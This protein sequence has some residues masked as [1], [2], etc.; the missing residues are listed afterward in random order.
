MLLMLGLTTVDTAVG[1]TQ[2]LL[3]LLYLTA[4]VIILI[5]G[6]VILL[7]F[8]LHSFSISVFHFVKDGRWKV[9]GAMI[10][11]FLVVGESEEGTLSPLVFAGR[12]L[13]PRPPRPPR[14]QPPWSD[15]P[16]RPL[17]PLPRPTS[18]ILRQIF[19]VLDI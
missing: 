3:E 13:F 11:H 17:R 15:R 7:I 4:L 16:K 18:L 19:V 12:P 8:V 5:L 1:N 9:E 2:L 14:P 6:S 10:L